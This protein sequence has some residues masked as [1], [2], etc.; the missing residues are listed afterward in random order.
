MTNDN[1]IE[2]CGCDAL[3][4]LGK[5]GPLKEAYDHL[6]SRDPNYF[7]T[8]GQWMTERK[9]GSDVGEISEKLSILYHFHRESLQGSVLTLTCIS[10][11]LLGQPMELK[12]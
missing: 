12:R 7:W 8:S 2:T 10:L 4:T 6:I 1:C 11:S 3:Q 5:R 9:G